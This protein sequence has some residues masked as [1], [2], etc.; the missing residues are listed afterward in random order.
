MK[1][2]ILLATLVAFLAAGCQK[3]EIENEVL[4]PIGF[5]TKVGK[6][7][8]AIVATTYSESQ[9][10][11][12]YAYGHQPQPTDQEPNNEAVTDIMTNI[13]IAKS[14][15][16]WKPTNNTSYYWPNDPST[17]I[18]FFAYSPFNGTNAAT[19]ANHE[20]LSGTISH[21]EEDGL[22]LT[23]YVHSNMYVDF[24]VADP[25][26]GA[27]YS[28]PDGNLNLNS[29]TDGVVP[30]NF[31]HKMT[32]IIFT[33]K[34]DKAY[35]NVEFT[36]NSITLNDIASKATYIYKDDA[37]GDDDTNP[38]A[39]APGEESDYQIF[40]VN[41]VS[42]NTPDGS[43]E[44]QANQAATEVTNT[45]VLTTAA[46]TMIPQTL[47]NQ[48]FTI[49]YSIEGTGVATETVTKTFKFTA[50]QTTAPTAPVWAANQKITY[51]LSIG[52]N[53]ITFI[54]SVADWST[55]TGDYDITPDSGN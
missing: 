53:E 24:M 45:S 21:N 27:K 44:L 48:S 12:V 33:V 28:N 38:W 49:V 23:D 30:A 40:P 15:E 41:M 26:I 1:R 31:N 32:Q 10:F 19:V 17:T 8:K 46:V 29:V 42:A 47:A 18:N 50:A 52:L 5:N 3:T 54:P 22:V 6:Q 25:V 4:T 11:G 51:N 43:P 7:T 2:F 36:V 9:P 14:G 34:T 39:P 20:K 13:E 35:S 37:D 55:S 16:S